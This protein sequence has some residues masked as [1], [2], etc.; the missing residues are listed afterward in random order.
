MRIFFKTA[1][2]VPSLWHVQ[3]AIEEALLKKSGSG[4]TKLTDLGPAL[5]PRLS[6][7][8]GELSAKK[9]RT[10]T[11]TQWD[12]WWNDLERAMSDLGLSMDAIGDRRT[13]YQSAIQD[14]LPVL[15]ANPTVPVSSGGFETVLRNSASLMVSGR[16]HALASIERC[17]ALFDL[18]VCRDHGV[19]DSIPA[20][21]ETLRVEAE[22]HGG[23]GAAP[24]IV[25]DA[26][27]PAPAS[28]SSLRDRDL[29]GALATSKGLT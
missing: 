10:M 24:R 16:T 2:L 5:H 6:D 27:P 25:A 15:R 7:L 9:L 13:K 20:V 3:E 23:W 18:C 22:K 4:A 12:A 29:P 26:Q 8:L 14:V 1:V 11:D 21:V 28:Y 17:A 19:F